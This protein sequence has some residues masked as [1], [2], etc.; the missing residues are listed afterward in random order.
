MPTSRS[1]DPYKLIEE[2]KALLQ[3]KGIE[4]Q[5]PDALGQMLVTGAFQMLRGLGVDP[6]RAPENHLD[7]DGGQHYDTRLHED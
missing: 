4:L 5:P 3:E 1:Y 7:L 2:V 6:L